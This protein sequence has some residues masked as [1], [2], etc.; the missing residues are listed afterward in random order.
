MM[1]V[2]EMPF[3]TVAVMSAIAFAFLAVLAC[4]GVLL[5]ACVGLA[6]KVRRLQNEVKDLKKQRTNLG[7]ALAHAEHEVR[8]LKRDRAKHWNEIIRLRGVLDRASRGRQRD[9]KEITYLDRELKQTRR[10]LTGAIAENRRLKRAND[11]L[12]VELVFADLRE[13]LEVIMDNMIL[14][15]DAPTIEVSIEAFEVEINIHPHE[16]ESIIV[17][18]MTTKESKPILLGWNP[19]I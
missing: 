15:P 8:E 3:T 4:A 14:R 2:I 10:L 12:E 17:A 7:G 5:L 13:N 18:G 1:T 16:I 19:T 11:A 6:R 9:A